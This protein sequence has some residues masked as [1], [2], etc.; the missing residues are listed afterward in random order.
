MSIQLIGSVGRV[1]GVDERN[2]AHNVF[3]RFDDAEIHQW[4]PS[5]V[6][7]PSAWMEPF[8]TAHP[9]ID[10][11][12]LDLYSLEFALF[13][14][15]VNEGDLRT[16][17]IL[18]NRQPGVDVE[19]RNSDGKTALH[20]ASRKG[21]IDLVEWLLNEAKVDVNKPDLK[22]FRAI[23]HAV[24]GYNYYMTTYNSNFI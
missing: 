17:K 19:A 5:D 7:L 9:A 4:L 3:I 20:I 8:Q 6:S 1:I 24:L 10:R 16:V 12:L 23:H 18:Y 21:Y 13:F 15:A 14:K 22:S 2:P 11:E